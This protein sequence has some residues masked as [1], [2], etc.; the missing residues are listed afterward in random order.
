M[1]NQPTTLTPLLACHD[2]TIQRGEFALCE[3]V[4]LQL[5]QGDICHLIGENGTGKTTFIMQLAGLIPLIQGEILWQGTPNLPIQP[6][7]IAHQVGIHLQLTVEQN[8]RFLLGLYGIK[9]TTDELWQALDWV[10]L[11]GYEDIA[12][13]QLS[14]GQTRRVGLSRLWFG[15]SRADSIPFWLLDEPL[16]A[17]DINMIAKVEKIMHDFANQGGTVL[18]T[19]HQAV[20]VANKTLNLQTFI[21]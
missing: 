2:V 14:A 3:N 12:C 5:Y 8:L 21:R 6:L 9:P 13:Y 16:T 7:Y 20:A 17:L 19:S 10:G 11:S 18:L 15:V 1:S 4:V